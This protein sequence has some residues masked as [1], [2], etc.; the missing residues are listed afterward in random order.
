MSHQLSLIV[1]EQ[2]K[3]MKSLG[4]YDPQL[5]T[6]THREQTILTGLREARFDDEKTFDAV[7]Y[8]KVR[9]PQGYLMG[10]APFLGVT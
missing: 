8:P 7:V 9:V 4:L 2:Q 3:V 5:P 1:F 6:Q 10:R